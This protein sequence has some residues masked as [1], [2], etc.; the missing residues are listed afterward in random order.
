MGLETVEL[1]MQVEVA[2]GLELPDAGAAQISTIGDL[3]SHLVQRLGHQIGSEELWERL[4]QLLLEKHGLKPEW[5]LPEMHF[6]R[7]LG[8]D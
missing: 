5:I 2:F 4:R 7:D 3:H 1:L 8:S 6:V